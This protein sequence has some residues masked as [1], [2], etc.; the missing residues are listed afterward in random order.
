MIRGLSTPQAQSVPD[1]ELIGTLLSERRAGGFTVGQ[2]LSPASA[3]RIEPHGHETAHV[4]IVTAG[5]FRSEARG[6]S[7]GPTIIFNPAGTYHRDHFDGEGAFLGVTLSRLTSREVHL[8][9][10]PAHPTRITGAAAFGIA[11]LLMR[12]TPRGTDPCDDIALEAHCFELIG[13]IEADARVDRHPP[14]W[15]KTAAEFLRDGEDARVES[16]ARTIGVH[17]VHLTRSFRQHF[18][19]TPG[20]FL[21]THKVTKAANLLRGRGMTIAQVAA[22]CAFYDQSHLVRSFRRHFGLTPQ[23]FRAAIA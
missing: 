5:S 19:C 13:Q 9:S 18:R 12:S 20:D 11:G 21:R 3:P 7:C 8:L 4:V 14:K 6:D 17:P 1:S 22:E 2:W 15:L 16:V 23:Q 10:L